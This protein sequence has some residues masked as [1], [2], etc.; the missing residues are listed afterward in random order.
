MSFSFRRRKERTE[1]MKITG[2]QL[3]WIV[4]TVE[5][6]MAVWLRISPAVET[7]KQDAWLS[8]LL[9]CVL[10]GAITYLAVNV[11]LKHPG[12]SLAQFSQELLGPW[13]GRLVPL[14]YFT[15]WF[16]LAGDVIRSFADFLHL[17][18][19]DKTPV[20]VLIA[21]LLGAAIYMTGTSGITGI[22]RFCEMVGPL[23]LIALLLSFLLNM[24]NAKWSNLLPLFGD[25]SLTEIMKASIA[26]SSFLGES[27]MLL[28]LLSFLSSSK[29]IMGKALSS[30]WLTGILLSAAT[31]MVLLVFGPAVAQELRFPYFMLVRSINIL[32]FIQNVDILVIF[33][34]IFGVFAKIA[35]YLFITSYEMAQCLRIKSWKRMIWLSAP[36]IFAIALVIPNEAAILL[37]QMLWET[38][39]IPVCA[40][41]IP[42]LLLI[43]TTLKGRRIGTE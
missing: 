22:G 28:V 36:L 32:N 34:W 35:L 39:V 29:H 6:V 37:L 33:I 26:P 31:V 14:P 27:F 19:L 3:F 16:I 20:W 18:L 17:V 21:M 5:V 30:V 1:N 42:L 24:G 8:M 15:A 7:A 12:R 23:T 2:W 9:A 4:A 25:A 38:I 43:A 13:I 10:G 40:I 11:G 41:A